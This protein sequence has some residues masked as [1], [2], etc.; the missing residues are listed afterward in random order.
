MRATAFATWS[1]S[2]LG[3]LGCQSTEPS[4]AA[5]T[6]GGAGGAP[7]GAGGASSG[8]PSTGGVTSAGSGVGGSA[9]G[10]AATETQL[11]LS[12]GPFASCAVLADQSVKCA[13]RCGPTGK[14]GSRDAAPPG[15]H[16]RAVA[17]GREFA[18]AL[19]PA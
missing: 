10:G 17:V 1:L 18:C 19:L 9:T 13:G 15:L 11:S 7:L 3:L 6:T 8:G 12:L 5:T 14:G 16:A 2:L 4:A